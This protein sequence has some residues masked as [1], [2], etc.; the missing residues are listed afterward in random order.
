MNWFQKTYGKGFGPIGAVI[1]VLFF[2]V[3][4]AFTFPWWVPVGWIVLFALVFFLN[5]N[6]K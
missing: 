6:T 2:A 4:F 1:F 5:R 3:Y